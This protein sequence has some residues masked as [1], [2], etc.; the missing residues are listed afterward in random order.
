MLICPRCDIAL[1]TERH[2]SE[3][4]ELHRCI[5]CHGV[6]VDGDDI[7]WV[8]PGLRRHGARIT[9]LLAKGARR[10]T[11]M[12]ACPRGHGDA[13]EFPFFDL[14]LDLCET[15]H[16]VWLDGAEVAFVER[17]GQEADG[18]P[19]VARHGGAYRE[20]EAVASETVTCVACGE[21]VH[22]RRTYLTGDGAVCDTCV[23]VRKMSEEMEGDTLG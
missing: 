17:A 16:G 19:E 3:E 5:D 21:A 15:C 12:P 23:E 13:I 20:Q 1:T 22:P 14:W 18:L 9:E 10:E 6:W 11:S 8:A 7:A 4:V 2:P